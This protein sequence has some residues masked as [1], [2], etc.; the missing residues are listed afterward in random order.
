MERLAT[1][2]LIVGPSGSGKT[3]LARR[4]I[5]EAHGISL[6]YP[7]ETR[8]FP[9]GD[10]Y[11]ARVHTSPY[12]FEIDIP[13]LSMQDKQIIGDLLTM[14]LSSGDVLSILR[15]AS[16]KLVVLRRAHCLSLPAA[17]R[18][19]AILQ[20]YVL[21]ANASGMV[22]MTAREITGPLSLL[23]DAFVR[24]RI[25]RMS[26]STWMHNTTIPSPYRTEMAWSALEG[27]PERAVEMSRFFPEGPTTTSTTSTTST[28]PWPRRIQDYYDEMV[29]QMI[30]GATAN[31][32]P[33]LNVVEWLRARVYEALS[34]CQTGPEIV[35]SCCAALARCVSASDDKGLKTV[36]W[37]VMNV[38]AE[39]EPHTSYRT[40][41]SLEWAILTMY[42][43]MRKTL[44]VVNGHKTPQTAVEATTH[45]TAHTAAAP[46]V[47]ACIS[48]CLESLQGVDDTITQK[49]GGTSQRT[50]AA[51]RRRKT[52]G[53]TPNK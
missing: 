4:W 43:E 31:R 36:F 48:S 34:F 5:E 26:V 45:N 14:F 46:P 8:I 1:P 15:S 29:A 18:V 40:P 49:A 51:P 42:E 12:H 22:W 39:S 10:G 32:S 3:T 24:H 47:A 20:Q 35:D 30:L 28:N 53:E 41:L 17:I 13:N 6:T 11:E 19:R 23:D 52:T 21:P 37:S 25:P 44:C 38:L 16:R 2:W 50:K 27:H 7:L 33:N 9:I